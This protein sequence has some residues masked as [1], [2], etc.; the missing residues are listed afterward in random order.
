MAKR[1]PWALGAVAAVS[2]GALA[3]VFVP[4]SGSDGNATGQTRS[5]EGSNGVE[6]IGTYNETRE[7]V[8]KFYVRIETHTVNLDAY[9]PLASIVLEHGSA[10]LTP[11][12]ASAVD[13]GSRSAHHI[14]ALLYFET[15]PTHGSISLIAKDLAGVP[16]RRLVFDA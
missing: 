8:S 1:L 14:S 13:E 2:A 16:E 4:Q 15:G 12:S 3:W 6:F 11:T 10:T 9:D 7:G 5:D